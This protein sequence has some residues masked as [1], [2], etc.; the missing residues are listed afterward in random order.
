M[1]LKLYGTRIFVVRPKGPKHP[2]IRYIWFLYFVGSVVMI[3][4]IRSVF[5]YLDP[6]GGGIPK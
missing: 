1:M 4:G 2:N 6:S 3:L 5:G